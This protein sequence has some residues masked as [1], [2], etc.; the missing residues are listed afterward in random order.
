MREVR[1]RT[2]ESGD[3][4]TDGEK[5]ELH[6]YKFRT[7]RQEDFVELFDLLH[8]PA[9]QHDVSGAH[10]EVVA[11]LSAL[12]G[13]RVRSATS[14]APAPETAPGLDPEYIESLKALGYLQ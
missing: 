10:P 3:T 6:T 4:G 5:R 7:D 14:D 2:S 8:D 1:F 13:E 12:L 9:E 11:S